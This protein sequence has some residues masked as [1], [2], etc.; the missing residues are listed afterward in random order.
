ME[1]IKKGKVSRQDNSFAKGC[2]KTQPSLA[3]TL[4]PTMPLTRC[5][6]RVTPLLAAQLRNPRQLLFDTNGK[7]KFQEAWVLVGLNTF[8]KT[9]WTNEPPLLTWRSQGSVFILCTDFFDWMVGFL[10]SSYFS[11]W[12]AVLCRHRLEKYQLVFQV[13]VSSKATVRALNGAVWEYGFV[14]HY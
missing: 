5:W 10:F 1:H 2:T 11:F 9:K 6:L 14:G 3:S 8:D 12:N 4:G 13:F 7:E